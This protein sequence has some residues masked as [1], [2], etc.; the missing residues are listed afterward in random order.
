M[1]KICGVFFF[2]FAEK[3]R[4]RL[5]ASEKSAENIVLRRKSGKNLL[6]LR[7]NKEG[8]S[9]LVYI[10]GR[11]PVILRQFYRLEAMLNFDFDSQI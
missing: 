9:A 4:K 6:A 11:N 10:F 2:R 3:M 8:F 5:S 7:K 1:R